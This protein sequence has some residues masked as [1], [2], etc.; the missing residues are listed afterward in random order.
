MKLFGKKYEKI[1]L[2]LSDLPADSIHRLI[3]KDGSFNIHRVGSPDSSLYQNLVEMKWIPFLIVIGFSYIFINCIFALLFIFAGYENLA[4]VAPADNYLDQFANSFFFSVQTFTTVG[5]GTIAPDSF[6]SDV[7]ASLDA[8]TGWFALAL[9]T[10]LLFA[11]FSRPKSQFLFSQNALIAPY[12]DGWSLQL[13]LANKRKNRI[14]NLQSRVL[15]TWLEKD[16]NQTMRRFAKLKLVIEKISLFPLNWTLIHVIDKDSPLDSCGKQELTKMHAEFLV[17]IDGHDETYAQKMHANT[18]YHFSEI[19]WFY[20]FV[21]MY[22]PDP[23][24]GTVI[25][26]AKISDIEDI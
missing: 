1:E 2:G 20:R 6:W 22:Y 15:M 18:S 19:K 21:R 17:L 11:R 23:D 9:S 25:D 26:L 13:R 10:G 4:G 14:I 8:L 5:Y 12:K 3:N 24:R 7:L 16:G